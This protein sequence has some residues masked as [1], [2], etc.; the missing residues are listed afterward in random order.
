MT[1]RNNLYRRSSGIYVLRISIPIRF[2]HHFGQREIHASTRCRDLRDAKAVGSRL[3]NLWNLSLSEHLA[4]NAAGKKSADKTLT[5]IHELSSVTGLP[6]EQVLRQVLS[7]QIPVVYEAVSQ[8]GFLVEDIDDVERDSPEKGGFV[9][10]SAIEVGTVH[11]FDR[12]LKVFN[13]RSTILRI[14]E[15]GISEEVVFRI[16]G[17]PKKREA[18]FF[19]L[20]GIVLTPRNVLILKIHAELLLSPSTAVSLSLPAPALTTLVAPLD[21]S[22][23]HLAPT[24]HH[25]PVHSE[26][27]CE[28]CRTER[29]EDPVSSI[30][31]TFLARKQA[32][33][34]LDQQKKME[35]QCT[36]FVELMGDPPLGSLNRQMVWDY[37]A[38]L[39]KMPANRYGAARR[40]GT[41]EA[42]R[43]LELAESLDEERLSP[44]SVE[45]YM[46]ALSSMFAWATQN[47]ILTSNP[48][49]GALEKARKITRAQDDRQPFSETEL[50][51]IFSA[52]W[53]ADGTG[54]RNS[55]GRLY[56]FR[57]HYYWLPLLGLYTGA[58]LNELSQL[59]IAD[60]GRTETDVYFLD[61]NLNSPDK[62]DFDGRDKSLK[63][64][65]SQRIVTLHPQ[66]IDLGFFDYI[67]ALAKAGY[68]RVFPELKHDAIKGYGKPAGSWFNER[69]LGKQLGMP[70]DGRRTFHSFRHTF[71]TA[72]SELD[73][74]HDIQSQLAGHS[75]GD[76]I[77]SKRYRKDTGPER[78]L[79]YVTLLDFN[80]PVIKPFV[81]SDG[82]DAVSEGL[83]RKQRLSNNR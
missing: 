30:L 4:S 80:L 62:T 71:I 68:Q 58:R 72:L 54:E 34:K 33:W 79:K 52:R 74:P 16:P 12:T 60:V 57:P 29:A 67:E 51:Q 61:F 47:M 48:A 44:K 15:T 3:L 37:E 45:R 65:D 46:D 77:T 14:I 55:R 56:Q 69:F 11:V 66:I 22:P 17:K 75:R 50:N 13:P 81:V 40:H 32:S 24:P 2:H 76:T 28:C 7:K 5:S 9:L 64:V 18:A 21:R 73:V 38:K 39:R 8:P 63:T 10:N 53:F 25:L 1:Q 23:R 49:E 82:L 41:N 27:A 20:P 43:L 70:R 6:I 31:A 42:S 59:Y 83:Q 78:L 26:Y 36:T 35:T 19:D